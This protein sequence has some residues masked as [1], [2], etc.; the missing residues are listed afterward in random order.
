LPPVT[1]FRPRAGWRSCRCNVERCVSFPPLKLIDGGKSLVSAG[2]NLA[3]AAQAVNA[4]KDCLTIK[5]I[6]PSR[7]M[8]GRT[9]F[10]EAPN[11]PVAA[12]NTGAYTIAP[13]DRRPTHNDRY[14]VTM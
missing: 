5:R 10:F 6:A 11:S 13:I 9:S 14:V 4:P 1:A 3:V 8:A 12:A 7:R 2:D